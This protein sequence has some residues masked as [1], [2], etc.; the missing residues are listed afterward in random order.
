MNQNELKQSKKIQAI[1]AAINEMARTGALSFSNKEIANKTKIL[2]ENKGDPDYVVDYRLLS[3][4]FYKENLEN[5]IKEETGRNNPNLKA[6]H[7]EAIKAKKEN[8]KK[9]YKELEKEAFKVVD[10][11]LRGKIKVEKFTKKFLIDEINKLK[12]NCKNEKAKRNYG[13]TIFSDEKYERIFHDAHARLIGKVSTENANESQ[14]I[15]TAVEHSKLKEELKR[16]KVEKK[17]LIKKM[18]VVAEGDEELLSEND[19]LYSKLMSIRLDPELLEN[20]LP[21]LAKF[22]KGQKEVDAYLLV[23]DIIEK[24]QKSKR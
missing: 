19:I 24:C 21:Y 22:H 18:F 2:F 14:K 12:E 6:A 23:M 17:A 5:W 3:K 11:I 13:F 10:M 20:H 15:I 4:P 16:Y 7:K 8:V 9:K 1:K